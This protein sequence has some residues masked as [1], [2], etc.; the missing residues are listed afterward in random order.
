MST[1]RR[2]YK[3]T[4]YLGAA[5]I[6]SKVLQFVVMLYAARLLS[7]ENFGKFSFAIALSLIA[8]VLADLGIDSFIIREISR[9]KNLAGEYFINA[10]LAKLILSLVTFLMIF[11]GLNAL[12]YP[13]DTRH[14]VY[15]IWMF[16]IIST[17]TDLFY[18]IF[19][20]FEIMVYDS[21]IK[22]IRMILLTISSLYVL[23]K[24]YGVIAFSYTF[25]FVEIAVVLIALFIALKKFIK[26]QII[27]RWKFMKTMLLKALPFGLST[28]F[29]MIYFF[30]GSIM[31]SKIRG[32]VEVAIY[33]VAY[34]LALAILFI[35]TVYTNA[36]YPVLSRYFKQS[37]EELNIL[38]EKSSKY[39]FI[40]GLPLSV[41][42]YL[43]AD[44]I[45]FFF[46]GKTYSKSIIALQI[47]SWYLVIKFINFHFGTVL[48][49]IDQ[50]NK[51]MIGQGVTAV[52]SIILNLLLIPKFGYAGAAWSTF[53]TEIF[54]FVIYYWYVSKNLYF[55]KFGDALSRPVIAAIAMS[56]F[57]KFTNFGLFLTVMLSAIIYI[58]L[59]FAMKTFDEKDFEIMRKIFKNEKIQSS[60]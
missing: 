26:L 24:G 7:V 59:I 50:Q 27:I 13:Q 10:L 33:S 4:L 1:A 39:L 28:V 9:N 48:S 3:N 35:P 47:I 14:I 44:R 29:G 12:D 56:L 18:S 46:Y 16:S 53:F 22:I 25:V 15:I 21:M 19:R 58:A 36:I 57:I 32:D 11:V 23:F 38:Y 41:G 54:L 37:K 55:Y 34:N 20:S 42:L 5:E 49:S 43:L 40:I 2:I 6:V 60:R 51:R 8:I 52:F 17:F 45:I 30:I 31:L